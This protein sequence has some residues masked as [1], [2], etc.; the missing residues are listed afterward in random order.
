MDMTTPTPDLCQPAH[1]RL[2]DAA[3][4]W[5]S[6]WKRYFFPA[7]WLVY[8]GQTVAGVGQHSHGAAAVVGYLLVVAFAACYL[9]ALPMGWTGARPGF[10]PMFAL[11][12][13]LTAAEAF[14]ARDSVLAFFVYLA[15]LAVAARTRW[16]APTVAGLVVAAGLLPRFVPGWGGQIEWNTAVTIGLVALA[17]FGFFS[18]IYSNIALSAARAEVARLAAENERTRIA[19][20]LHDLLGHSLTT[21]TV[22]AGLARR[23]AGRDPERSLAEIAEVEEL[24]RRT[25]SEVRAAVA[26]YRDVTLSGE[27][28]AARGILRAAGIDA[29]LPGAIDIVDAD[30]AEPFGWV[31]REA[32]TNVVRHSRASRCVITVGP[33]W[34]EIADDGASATPGAAGNGLTG[35]R[36]RLAAVGGTVQAGAGARGWQV[37]AVAPAAAGVSGLSASSA[38]RPSQPQ[39]PPPPVSRA[40]SP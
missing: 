36:E 13:G 24:A 4:M 35:L 22:K 1:P 26:G 38:P 2:E 11:G 29:D 19:R 21:I 40:A 23:L 15:V 18:I 5:G 10:W 8:L 30:V 16:S 20:D 37:R 25:M 14:F 32:V 34:I 31:V 39:E 33:R 6:G 3:R 12:V 28:A 27:L 17:M 7:F 9:I